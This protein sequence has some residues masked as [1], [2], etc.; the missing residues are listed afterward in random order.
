[1]PYRV[2]LKPAGLELPMMMKMQVGWMV[3][4]RRYLTE[5]ALGRATLCLP[6]RPA[7]ALEHLQVGFAS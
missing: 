4:Q 7:Q 2:S 6:P 5:G 1:M 3:S